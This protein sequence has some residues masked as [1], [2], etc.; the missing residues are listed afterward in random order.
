MK[1]DCTGVILA[2]GRNSRLPG[3]KKS[4]HRVGETTML[5]RTCDL[6]SDLFREIILVVNDP[7]DFIG[8]DAM[9]VTDIIPAGCALA[10]LHSGLFHASYP[11]AYVTACDF[12]F[13]SR[14]V[15]EYLVKRTG[16][17][18]QVVIPRTPEGLEPLTAVYAK[19]CIPLIE[20]NLAKEIFMIKKFFNKKR[21]REIPF[22]QLKKLDPDLNFKFNVNTPEDLARA[23]QLVRQ[24]KI[25]N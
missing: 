11:W 25:K 19:T 15:I 6:F 2:G 17:G 5:E 4:F 22:E 24:L 8:L 10:G 9:V 23:R 13:A 21:V 20:K 1:F 7:G 18:A 16:P 3:K 14:A 12:P